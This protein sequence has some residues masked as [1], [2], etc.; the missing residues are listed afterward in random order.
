MAP[1]FSGAAWRCAWHMI[2]NDLIHAWGGYAAWLLCTGKLLSLLGD[3]TKNV[4][5]LDAE[6]IIHYGHPTLGGSDENEVRRESYNEMKVFKR[7]WERAVK[8]E[9]MDL[10]RRHLSI[11]L[12]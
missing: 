12:K 3:R 11:D 2:Q 9:H 6:Y 8:D 7:K 1:V 4:G 5:V 10:S